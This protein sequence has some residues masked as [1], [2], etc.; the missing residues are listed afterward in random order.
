[1]KHNRRDQLGISYIVPKKLGI[2]Y[3]VLT[4][5]KYPYVNVYIK[6]ILVE[7]KFIKMVVW[8]FG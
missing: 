5:Q 4:F 8:Y 1:M 3:S 7:N 2:V 6:Q